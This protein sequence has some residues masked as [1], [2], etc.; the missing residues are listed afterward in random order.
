[1]TV[2]QIICILFSLL[3]F[4]KSGWE[5]FGLFAFANIIFPVNMTV[6]NWPVPISPGTYLPLMYILAYFYENGVGP[7]VFKLPNKW[8]V[9][10][11]SLVIF[12]TCQ[13]D[14]RLAIMNKFTR[15]I[16]VSLSYFIV[17]PFLWNDIKAPISP[18]RI[19][20]FLLS[21]TVL[22]FSYSLITKVVGS[23]PY[24]L[25]ISTFSPA[26]DVANLY[27]GT[28]DRFRIS[29]FFG[30]PMDYGLICA[31][32]MLG[33]FQLLELKAI[34]KREVI[35]LAL[36]SGVSV[37]MAN[38]RLPMLLWIVA[39]G[40]AMLFGRVWKTN[41]SIKLA[42]G[43]SALIIGLSF[44]TNSIIGQTL[45]IFNDSEAVTGSSMSMRITQLEA[46]TSLALQKPIFGHGLGYIVETMGF[47]PE[48]KDGAVEEDFAGFESILFAIPIEQGYLGLATLL[49]IYVELFYISLV[50]KP[51][52]T[53][54][55]SFIIIV[56]FIAY[57]IGTGMLGSGPLSMVAILTSIR[58]L[59][60]FNHM[61][62]ESAEPIPV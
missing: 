35:F 21:T 16:V 38:S 40:S 51:K 29:S 23:N 52:M 60:P 19:K 32:W 33:A 3:F 45:R 44:G 55:Y 5:R 61:D 10:I 39:F 31:Y 56:L 42:T 49:L 11:F 1:M 26:P 17:L 46:S 9:C 6:L 57:Q 53:W 50:Q 22:M 24:H 13:I 62:K 54:N 58:L 25:Y 7:S 15:P 48:E 27:M 59:N 41:L 36:V 37:G 34:S 18:E 8:S 4:R 14:P 28:N 30:H 12:I 2:L 47:N 43:I 20:K